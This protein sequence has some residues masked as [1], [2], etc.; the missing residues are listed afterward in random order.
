MLGRLAE[1]VRRRLVLWR[2]EPPTCDTDGCGDRAMGY[3]PPAD[4]YYCI[5]HEP[6]SSRLVYVRFVT[7]R[8]WESRWSP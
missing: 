7:W 6:P 3:I 2:G 5:S 8:D 4:E 1:R